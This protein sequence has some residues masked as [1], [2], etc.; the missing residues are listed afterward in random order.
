MRS[1][2]R[3]RWRLAA[4]LLAAAALVVAFLL[5][6]RGGA[7][8][9][10][11]PREH[12]VVLVTLDTLRLDAFLGSAD[13]PSAMEELRERA[14]SCAVFD[15]FYSATATT[16][17][18]HASMLTG[19]QPWQHGVT[20]NL[21]PLDDRFVTVAERLQRA[22]FATAA[23]VASY[24]VSRQ[25]GLDQ[26]FSEFHD[27]FTHELAR[28]PGQPSP[29]AG[30]HF[31]SLA[32]RIT[33]RAIEVLDHLGGS[34]PQFLWVHYFDPHE[35]YGDTGPGPV[36]RPPEVRDA[37]LREHR[38]RK[39]VLARLHS[40]YELDVRFLD[41]QLARLLSRLDA[42]RK[43]FDTDVLLVADH[44]ESLG[45]DGSIGH[46]T[47]LSEWMIHVP[48]VLCSERVQPGLRHDVAGSIDVA[49]TL[50]SLAGQAGSDVGGRDLTRAPTGPT[51]AYG[52]RRTYRT[53]RSELRLDGRRYRIDEPLFYFVDANGILHRGNGEQLTGSPNPLAP[54]AA[55]RL[56][57]QFARFTAELAG[58][59]SAP[60]ATPEAERALRALGYV[61]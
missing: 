43:R 48:L 59:P 15:R 8:P 28:A 57:R 18:S 20:A 37:I 30:K 42:D 7:V 27:D 44:G 31:Y 13:R 60:K 35:P 54:L 33:D 53:R 12:R 14:G 34:G 2:A 56:R 39:Q 29:A 23:V 52:M 22:R 24:P 5:V 46:G 17:P 61:P 19:L 25:S 9:L 47:Q 55:R 26:G 36:L 49:A 40:L 6:L 50:L 32:D 51:V 1:V 41:H 58:R 4:V 38:D 45:E 10:R 11:S 16:Q 3:H 21:V